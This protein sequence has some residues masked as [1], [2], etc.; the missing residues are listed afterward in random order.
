MKDSTF[1]ILLAVAI[2]VAGVLVYMARKKKESS[3]NK[4]EQN[5]K[6]EPEA[7]EPEKTEAEAEEPEALHGVVKRYQDYPE[8][9]ETLQKLKDEA[10][11]QQLAAQAVERLKGAIA[12]EKEKAK[13]Q[14]AQSGADGKLRT[15][16]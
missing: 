1:I 5:T 2:V 11:K 8:S 9:M 14:A 6:A 7:E 4:K 3:A 10:S 15:L 13:Q 12:E 16:K